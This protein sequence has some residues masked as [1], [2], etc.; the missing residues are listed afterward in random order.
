MRVLR[1]RVFE[2]DFS[3]RCI[4]RTRDSRGWKSGLNLSMMERDGG[5]EI[6]SS[7]L[8]DVRVGGKSS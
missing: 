6:G 1:E 3:R 7:G 2:W 8:N 5:D 4:F